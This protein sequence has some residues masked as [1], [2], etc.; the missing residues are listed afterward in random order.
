MPNERQTNAKKEKSA[1]TAMEP[2]RRKKK[3]L[4]EHKVLQKALKNA[5]N[6]RII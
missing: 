2:R 3:V 4:N 5:L 1:R 6:E